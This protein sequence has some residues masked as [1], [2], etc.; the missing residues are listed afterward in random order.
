MRIMEG[1]KAFE[2]REKFVSCFVDCNSDYYRDNILCGTAFLEKGSYYG[3]LWEC[4]LPSEIESEQACLE[5]L[6]T[7]KSFYVLWDLHPDVSRQKEYWKYPKHAV[8]EMNVQDYMENCAKLPE[9]I[10]IF[11]DSF[12][13]SIALTHESNLKNERWCLFRRS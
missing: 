5:F 3:Y 11:D 4:Y 6:A 10:Y 9:D 7:I 1:K 12:S 8:L 2:C 13:W